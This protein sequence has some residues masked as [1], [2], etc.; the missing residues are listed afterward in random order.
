[1]SLEGNAWGETVP[2]SRVLTVENH[3]LVAGDI[4][5][6]RNLIV[7]QVIEVN[8]AAFDHRSKLGRM[9]FRIYAVAARQVQGQA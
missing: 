8:L 3:D 5:H 6:S 1:M 4:H 9:T 7:P 2:L